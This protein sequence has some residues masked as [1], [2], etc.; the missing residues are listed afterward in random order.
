MPM[1][2]ESAFT[3]YI[4]IL[5]PDLSKLQRNIGRCRKNPSY[6]SCPFTAK[7]ISLLS[8]FKNNLGIDNIV[9]Q[10]IR[11]Q[12]VKVVKWL[13]RQGGPNLFKTLEIRVRSFKLDSKLYYMIQYRHGNHQ[14]KKYFFPFSSF[15]FSSPQHPLGLVTEI[16]KYLES[17]IWLYAF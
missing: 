7:Y 8:F 15:L 3:E 12:G 10:W 5:D 16:S 4:Y 2:S 1:N 17:F 9:S 6:R 13:L 14:L 11:W